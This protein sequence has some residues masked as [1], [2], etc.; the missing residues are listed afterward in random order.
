MSKDYGPFFYRLAMAALASR[1]LVFGRRKGC[2]K[3]KKYFLKSF[4]NPKDQRSF[5]KNENF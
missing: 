4:N 5:S 2:K 1:D 3:C